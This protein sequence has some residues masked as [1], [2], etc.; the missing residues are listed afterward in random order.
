MSCIHCVFSGNELS[1]SG[2]RKEEREQKD[3]VVHCRERYCGAFMRRMTLPRSASRD[4]SKI[5]AQY[6]NGVLKVNIPK[7]PDKQDQTHKIRID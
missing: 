3:D 5:T 4:P 1:I 6:E 7:R 2:E